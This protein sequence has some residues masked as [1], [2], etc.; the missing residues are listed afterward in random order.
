M[1]ETRSNNDFDKVELL[2]SSSGTAQETRR[3]PDRETLE[4][5]YQCLQHEKEDLELREKIRV[6]ETEVDTMRNR[7]TGKE[8]DSSMHQDN[9][10]D[11]V[12]ITSPEKRRRDDSESNES[13][14]KRRFTASAIKPIKL[15][16]YTGKSYRSYKEYIRQCEKVY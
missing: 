7:L 15:E 4:H 11:A 8:P 12:V 6:L 5:R 9:E 10:S 2:P 14:A 3:Q 16:R 1:S 13:R